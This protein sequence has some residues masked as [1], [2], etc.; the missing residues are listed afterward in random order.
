[1]SKMKTKCKMATVILK[2]AGLINEDKDCPVHLV[3]P[4]S[5]THPHN[6]LIAQALN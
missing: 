6:T 2:G 4:V 5:S 1:M 3:V